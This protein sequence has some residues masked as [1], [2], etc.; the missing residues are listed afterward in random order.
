MNIGPYRFILGASLCSL[1]AMTNAL[2][3]SCM[4]HP[5]DP[6]AA[7]KQ[8]W[9]EADA[10][11]SGTVVSSSIVKET[12]GVEQVE[13]VLE[14]RRRW[15][16][17]AGPRLKVRT[18]TSSAACGYNFEQQRQYV[19]FARRDPASNVYSTGLCSL[20]QPAIDTAPLAEALGRM[21]LKEDAADR[22]VQK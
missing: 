10:I 18:P 21:E 11:V 5:E 9:P 3:C 20:T 22:A 17:P 15:K 16:G 13:V 2:A 14:V 6:E 12:E 8:A 7:V 1:L 19:V 4:P